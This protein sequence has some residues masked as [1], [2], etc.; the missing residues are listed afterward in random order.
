MNKTKTE[1]KLK[2]QKMTKAHSKI[3]KQKLNRKYEKV[4]SKWYTD[5][6]KNK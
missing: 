6:Y 4:T 5:L 3:N 1:I 2:R